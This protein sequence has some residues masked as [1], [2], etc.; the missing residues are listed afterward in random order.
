[1]L[2][3]DEGNQNAVLIDVCNDLI[4]YHEVLGKGGFATIYRCT[5]KGFSFACKWID[6]EFLAPKDIEPIKKEISI[7]KGN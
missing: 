4:K 1:V 3:I 7:M 5:V 6:T 2:N